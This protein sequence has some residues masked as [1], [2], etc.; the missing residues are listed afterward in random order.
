M[1]FLVFLFCLCGAS[2]SGSRYFTSMFSL[3]DSYIDTGNFVIMATPVVPVWVDK[4]PY[5]M[6]FFGRPTGRHSD[7]RVI[8]DFIGKSRH[9]I[10]SSTRRRTL[11]KFEC[12][13]D[14]DSVP[15]LQFPM[16][17][18]EEFGLPFLQVSLQV[19]RSNVSHGVNFAVGG[20]TAIDVDFFE[21]SNLVQFK[22]L[23]N[24][25]NVQLGWFEALKPWICN[26]TEGL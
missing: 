16:V 1:F 2:A 20:A 6:T 23:N 5:G 21:R 18:A 25:L 10:H 3:G 12:M 14:L 9:L 26:T 8:I 13:F 22:L 15:T 4:P 19:S 24:S 17:V 7:G 11:L